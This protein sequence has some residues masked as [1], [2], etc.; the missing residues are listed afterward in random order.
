MFGMGW[1][2]T[3]PSQGAAAEIL[4]KMIHDP[5]NSS[6]TRRGSLQTRFPSFEQLAYKNKAFII[7][8][9]EARCTTA[10]KLA[11]PNFPLTGSV[12]SRNHVLATFVHERLEWSPVD[13]SPEQSETEWLC[14]DVAVHKIVN[15]YKPPRWRF[16]STAILTFRHPVCTLMTSTH[17]LPTIIYVRLMN[18]V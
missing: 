14:V 8:L 5:T 4:Q 6:W 18:I 11:I 1:V 3:R 17:C 9:Q 13:Q 12:L 2:M 16:T 7:V 15:V 10:E